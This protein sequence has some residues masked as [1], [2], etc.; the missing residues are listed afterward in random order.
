MLAFA[1]EVWVLTRTSNRAVIEADPLSYAPG[2][3]FIYYDLPRWALKLKK[4]AWFF[5][6]YLILWQWGAYRL[7][8]RHHQEQHFDRVYHVTFTSMHAGS[9][10]GRLGIPFIIGP[11]AGG[12]RAPFSLWRSMPLFCQL[13]ELI[14]DFIIVCVRHSPLTRAAFSSAKHIYVTTP[15][16]LRLVLSKWHFKTEVQL[17]VAICSNYGAKTERR[18]SASPRFVFVGRLLYWKGVHFAIRA[19]AEVRKSSPAAT[20]T[21]I[22][23][24]AD[25]RWLRNVAIKYGVANAVEFAGQIPRQQLIRSLQNHTA[26]VFPSLHDSG[27][28]VVLESLS[29]GLPVVCLDLGGPGI[30]VNASCGFVVPTVDT[31]DART[32]SGVADAMISLATMSVAELADLSIG[33]V[34]RAKELS[35]VKLTARIAGCEDHI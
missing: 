23:S 16:G 32:V 35:W 11:I 30:M 12:E 1:D 13:K 17:S 27:G 25:E 15:D 10:M 28:M 14:R 19:M 33:A 26:L 9:F 31:D 29:M 4:E 24:G 6:I 5:P 34:A 3:H 21:L 7:A 8:A 20:L 18:P 22:G 2:L